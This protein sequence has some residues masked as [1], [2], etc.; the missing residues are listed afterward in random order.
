MTSVTCIMPTA[1]RRR[2]VPSA[3]ELFLAQDYEDRELVIVDDGTDD[4]SDLVPRHPQIRYFRE[5]PGARS[6]GEKRNLACELSRGDVIL[7]WDDDDWHAPWR[8]RC[9]VE[10][11]NSE[12]LDLCGL[13]RPLFVDARAGQ[14]WEYT[15]TSAASGWLCG[16]TLGYRKTFWREHRFPDVRIGEDTRFVRFAGGARMGALADNRF[17]LARIHSANTATKRPQGRWPPRAI[18]LVRSVVGSDWDR[19]F[20]DHDGL[21]LPAPVRKAGTALIVVSASV[22]DMVGMTPIIRAAYYLGYDVDVQ[23]LGGDSRAADLLRGT[24]EIRRLFSE[25]KAPPDGRS[26]PDHDSEANAYDLAVFSAASVADEDCARARQRYVLDGKR[27]GEAVESLLRSLGWQR[28]VPSPFVGTST[29]RFGLAPE[30]I[31]LHADRRLCASHGGL[32]FLQELSGLF[33]QVAL[34]GGIGDAGNSDPAYCW[35]AGWPNAVHNFVGQ[36]DPR[37]TTALLSQCAAFVTANHDQ[38]ALGAA[39][40]VPTFGIPVDDNSDRRH[41]ESQ[42]F[43]P[44]VEP[45]PVEA[46]PDQ[47][48]GLLKV[49]N[50]DDIAARV[51]MRLR[52]RSIVRQ[53]PQVGAQRY[54]GRP[55]PSRRRVSARVTP[56]LEPSPLAAGSRKKAVQGPACPEVPIPSEWYGQDYFE[57]ALRRTWPRGYTWLRCGQAFADTAAMLHTT[58]PSAT[59][60]LDAGCAKGFLVR[61]LVERGLE[62]HGFDHSAWAIANVEPTVRDLVRRAA[63]DSVE[64]GDQTVDVV[65]AMSLLEHLTENQIRLFLTRA[66]RWVRQ[67]LFATIET[68]SLPAASD[69]VQTSTRDRQWWCDRFAESGW[70]PSE[71]QEAFQ[72]QHLVWRMRWTAYALE[73]VRA[74]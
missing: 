60:Y 15:L 43:E 50:A 25:R 3:I 45:A 68:R 59:S 5:P 56:R 8:I 67:A 37:D 22:S 70:R 31:A 35:T 12:D 7:H 72:R 44:I 57:G 29:R 63:L 73:P 39:L 32:R 71:L 10:R 30:T 36:L 42:F 14:A 65:V 55:D 28:E 19:Y 13:D 69:P 1:N 38:M 24:P 2:F 21:P 4:V 54:V 47:M 26:E 66:R 34:V 53:P 16:A 40:C 48:H 18:E 46:V 74:L 51:I 33:A 62:A 58:F 11:L 41:I 23:M 6:L 17:F 27:S 49:L 61:A 20:G 9:Q 52:A 64:C